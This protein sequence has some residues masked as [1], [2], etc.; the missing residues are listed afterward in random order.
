MSY[1]QRMLKLPIEKKSQFL[2]K[3]IAGL[4]LLWVSLVILVGTAIG[5]PQKIPMPIFG[6]GY[7]AGIILILGN[8]RLNKNFSLG[9]PSPF[10]KRMTLISMII[11]IILLLLLGGPHFIDQDYRSIWLGA[12]LAIGIHFIPFSFVH[13]KLMLPLAFFMITNALIGMIFTRINFDYIAYINVGIL[14]VYGILF[15]F[16]EERFEKQTTY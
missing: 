2:N 11:M 4:W 3:K 15:F 16:S 14:T 8:K 13:G 10:Q 5:G 6:L 7:M 12:F 9:R 1:I